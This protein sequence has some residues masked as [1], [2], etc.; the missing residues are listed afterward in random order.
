MRRFFYLLRL[1][2][3]SAWNRRGTLA[4]VVFSVALSTALLLGI[5]RVRGQA[6]ES[7]RQSVSGTDLVVGARGSP[8]QLMLYAIFH[9]GGAT[10]EISWDS[11]RRIAE[12]SE[13]AWSIP[14]ALGDSHQGYPV[15]A[16]TP[17]FFQRYSYRR[18]ESLRFAQGEPFRDLYDL[19]VGAEA[20]KNLGYR[21]GS[22]LTLAHGSGAGKLAEHTDKPFAVTGVL[23]PTGTPVDRSLYI[24]LEAMEAIHLDWQGGAPVPGFQVRADQARKFNLEPKRVTA[25]L[26][27][28]KNRGRVFALQR[29][30][31]DYPGEAL[32]G[33]MPGV[34]MDQLWTMI[35]AGERVLL[36]VSLLVTVTGL[37]GL[38]AAILA[39]LGERR[40]ELAILRSAGAGPLDIVLLLACEGLL[41]MSCGI[42]AGTAALALLIAGLGPV[43]ADR[44]GI[45]LYLSPPV[46]REWA[47]LGG[48]LLAGF[49]AGLI[50]A[51]RAYRLSLADGLTVST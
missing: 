26:L 38:A 40:R 45:A 25:L 29:Q 9:L 35:G 3:Q 18:G 10:S 5:E 22:V 7:F 36:L 34:A 8:L 6:R 19:V 20:A 24:S 27:G 14:L 12:R 13:V 32:M 46:A 21:P 30:V 48:I 11:A 51:F 4:L 42:L 1:S 39:G 44:Y 41:L 33:V 49:L 43:L 23:R 2:G 15:V 17:A 47:I 50:P 37:M 16:T 31:N 28:L